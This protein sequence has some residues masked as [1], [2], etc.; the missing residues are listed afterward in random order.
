VLGVT[1]NLELDIHSFHIATPFTYVRLSHMQIE[2]LLNS[3]KH[4]FR[5]TPS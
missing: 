5:P 3:P 2:E 4:N 1:N